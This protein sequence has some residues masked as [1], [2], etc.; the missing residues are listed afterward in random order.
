MLNKLTTIFEHI[1]KIQCACLAILM[2]VFVMLSSIMRYVVGKPFGFT[3]EVVG[4]LFIVLIFIGMPLAFLKR[5]HMAVSIVPD[6]S[7][8]AVRGL[9]LF[10][11]D[12]I[13]LVFLIWFGWLAF[14]YMQEAYLLNARSTGSRMLLWPWMLV[15]PVS[16]A[17]SCFFVVLN[18]LRILMP[19]SSLIAFSR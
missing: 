16:A 14:N 8:P 13:A 6:K 19:R 1:V 9:L 18:A 15:L 3:E 10:S 2:S 5:S 12:V 11:G 7:A 17:F 4:I